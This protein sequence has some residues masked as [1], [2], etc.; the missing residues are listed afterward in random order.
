V[1]VRLG[2][3]LASGSRSSV[4]AF[5]RDAVAKVPFAST[6]EA[7]IHFEARYT[8]AV[9]DAG[10]PAPRFL[11]IE[12]IG[13]R[14][15][16]IYERVHGR[17][18]WEHMLERPDQ[19][20]AH[21]R[22]LAELQAA[23]FL[24]VPPVSLPALRDRLSCKIGRAAALVDPSLVAALDLLPSSA[25]SRVCHGDLH[26]GNIIM[27]PSG[28]VLIDWF[29]AARGVEL[30]DVARTS[31]LMSARAHGT[32]GPSHL[33]GSHPQLLE[34]ARRSYL[35]A[36]TQVVEPR[37]IDLRRWEAVV[38]VARIAEGIA[39]EALLAIWHEWRSESPTRLVVGSGGLVL[40]DRP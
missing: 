36:I 25:T 20:R 6:P 19:V 10:A 12:T 23:L 40:H 13:G 7:W 39:T 18:M 5:G 31:L 32:R 37:P 9:H 3:Q 8:A 24:L 26:P 22:T 30:A 16:S 33:P 11:G 21:T 29:D 4:F 14:A 1:G 27:S 35:E 15:A 2:E 34:L 28:P 17:S 38:A